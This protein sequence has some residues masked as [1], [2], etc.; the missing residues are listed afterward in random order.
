MNQVI[1]FKGHSHHIEDT[2]LFEFLNMYGKLNNQL[3]L[4]LDHYE[5]WVKASLNILLDDIQHLDMIDGYKEQFKKTIQLFNNQQYIEFM[6][7]ASP[8]IE[9]ILKNHLININ[10][11]ILS[12]RKGSFVEKSCSEV[13]KE[14]KEN[15]NLYFDK[16][17]L[18][19][20]TYVMTESY[21]LNLRNHIA[22]G[23]FSDGAY[24]KSNSMFLFIILAYL[25]RY[26]A[27]DQS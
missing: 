21:G 24:N 17:I 16:N 13:I 25:I 5:N 22:H 12:E 2:N 26:F 18:N 20:I 23:S 27:N 6:Y 11:N 8:M 1:D 14:L 3:F 19:Y 9:I 15:E 10:G 4:Y 7:M